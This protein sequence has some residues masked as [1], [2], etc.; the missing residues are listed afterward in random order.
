MNRQSYI[1]EGIDGAKVVEEARRN[2]A[3]EKIGN[4]VRG[5]PST[6]VVHYHKHGESCDGQKHRQFYNGEEQAIA[7]GPDPLSPFFAWLE[8]K[9]CKVTLV[10]EDDG[11]GYVVAEILV[12]N[13]NVYEV[14]VRE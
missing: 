11:S 8:T 1:F 4:E 5:E 14:T 3:P 7:E 10:Q 6:V 12:P 13:Q 9:G 2:S